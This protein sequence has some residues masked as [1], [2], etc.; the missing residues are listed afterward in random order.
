[1]I[2]GDAPLSTTEMY[3]AEGTFEFSVNLPEGKQSPNIVKIDATSFMLL[4]GKDDT[5]NTKAWLFDTINKSWTQ[6]AS[7]PRN[8]YVFK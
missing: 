7:A 6:V 4:G 3:T 8:R 1:M 5:D 2:P